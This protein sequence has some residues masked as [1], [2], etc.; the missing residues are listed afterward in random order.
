MN[1]RERRPDPDQLLE[2]IREQDSVSAKGKLK[3]F[4]GAAPG[5]GK[6]HTMLEAARGLKRQGV[7]VVIGLIET[8]GRREIQAL[9]EGLESFPEADAVPGPD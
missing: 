6:T 2:R 4:L 5:V 1:D 8:H 9:Q 7:D 3:V